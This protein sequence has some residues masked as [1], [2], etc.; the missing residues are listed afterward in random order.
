MNGSKGH[1]DIREL[2]SSAHA[3]GSTQRRKDAEI[4]KEARVGTW[5]DDMGN[6]H[7]DR[8]VRSPTGFHVQV[9]RLFASL[10]AFA[11]LRRTQSALLLCTVC[12]VAFTPRT[13]SAQF[14]DAGKI[15]ETTDDVLARSEFRHLRGRIQEIHMPDGDRAPRDRDAEGNG[16]GNGGRGGGDA[17]DRGNGRNAAPPRPQRDQGGPGRGDRRIT[18]T[19]VREGGGGGGG[20]SSFGAGGGAGGAIGSFLHFLAWVL[21]AAIVG[22]I[23]YFV[24]RGLMDRASDKEVED[25]GSEAPRAG[26]EEAF[27]APGDR[28]ADVYVARA[29]QLASSGRFHEAVAQLMLGAMS[30]VEHR[31]LLRFRRGLTFRNYVSALSGMKVAQQAFRALVRVFEPIEYGRREATRAHFEAAIASYEEGFVA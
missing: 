14:R 27:A 26:E 3:D 20:S 9:V 5:K 22:L 11:P 29:R 31:E 2:R 28:P 12:L 23:L 24:L 25:E 21:L 15:R 18:R 4:R 6:G 13:A 19:R 10:C 1:I 30:F 8:T 16:N 7:S 17:G